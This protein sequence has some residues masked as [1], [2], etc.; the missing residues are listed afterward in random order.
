MLK[1]PKSQRLE[2]IATDKNQIYKRHQHIENDIT[3][4]SGWGGWSS[5]KL[6]DIEIGERFISRP[7]VFA[8]GQDDNKLYHNWWEGK[9]Y[10]NDGWTGWNEFKEAK[11]RQVKEIEVGEFFPSGLVLFAIDND[12][13]RLYNIQAMFDKSSW[14]NFEE[15]GDRKYKEIEVGMHSDLRLEIFAIGT[16]EKL[17]S[18]G[19]TSMSD[20]NWSSG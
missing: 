18:R 10:S 12:D 6:E 7:E 14:G 4:W 8:I 17:Y 3:N 11:N 15:F 5:K 13:S 16:D 9:E 2:V 19:M 20:F 1:W